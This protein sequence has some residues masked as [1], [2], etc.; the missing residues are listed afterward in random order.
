MEL[1]YFIYPTCDGGCKHCWSSDILL[2]RYKSYDW[3]RRLI[4]TL[5][6][7][8]DLFSEVKISGGEP[9][10]HPDI[11]KIVGAVQEHW[12]DDIPIKILTSGREFV[13]VKSG[14]IGIDETKDN[15][16]RFIPNL[17]NISIEM[18]ADEYH[19][20]SLASKNKWNVEE[21]KN[22]FKNYISNFMLACFE[23]QSQNLFF[24]GPKLK[25]HCEEHR[26]NYHREELL[27]W[28]PDEWW[29]KNI[30]LTEGLVYS[31]NAKK[32]SKTF[33]IK[34]SLQISYF[35]LP[36]VDFFE[37]PQTTLAQGFTKRNNMIYLDTCDDA[38]VLISGWWNL[39]DRYADY[40]S[41]KISNGGNKL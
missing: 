2:G 31:G 8:R 3:H 33:K 23:L 34:P 28:I 35:L 38:A 26:A 27:S 21:Q 19:L 18:S 25:I 20:Q 6:N 17:K 37:Q 13:S 29:E 11:G 36:G 1:V 14:K 16:L 39:I 4:A 32:L 22:N 5:E 7:K 10:L 12:G 15:I 24:K 40:E 41:I 9:F 30:I